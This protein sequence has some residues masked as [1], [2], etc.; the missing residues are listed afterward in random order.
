MNNLIIIIPHLS[1]GGAERVTYNLIKNLLLRDRVSIHLYMLKQT[2]PFIKADTNEKVKYLKER[3][4]NIEITIM[5]Y[6]RIIRCIPFL[7]KLI[8][9]CAE[10]KILCVSNHVVA[11]ALLSK[12]LLKSS[13]KIYPTVHDNLKNELFFRPTFKNKVISMILSRLYIRSEKIICVSDGIRD[14]LHSYFDLPYKQLIKIYNPIL[15]K[16]EIDSSNISCTHRWLEAKEKYEVFLSVGSLRPQKNF[17]LLIKSFSRVYS[18]YPNSRLIIL[19]EG[20]LKEHLNN[21][22]NEL[23]IREYVDLFG[24]TEN[25]SYFM[26]KADYYVLSSQTEA[27]PTVLVE[28]LFHKMKIIS[29][30]C[31]FGPSE[32]L[33]D[34]KYGV[35]VPNFSEE[36]LGSEMIAAIESNVESYPEDI[37]EF[38]KVFYEEYSTQKYLDVFEF[39]L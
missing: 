24:Y 21:L 27:L 18:A 1:K 15:S 33:K 17:E 37:D 22:V 2:D 36:K 38:L 31:E 10:S 9:S 30:D 25:V 5:P 34:G 14:L 23:G 19:G 7:V 20:E 4:S 28:A 29:V 11:C 3:C 35:L 39:K 13:V 8:N 16:K 6:S 12:L 32:I 26:G